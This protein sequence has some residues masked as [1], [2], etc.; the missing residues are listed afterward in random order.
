[1]QSRYAWLPAHEDPTRTGPYQ[2]GVAFT[3]HR[4]L[5]WAAGGRVRTS[6][7]TPG[8][9]IVTGGAGIDWLRVREPTE[10]LEVYPSAALLRAAAGGAV[11]PGPELVVGT[12][13]GVVLGIASVLR[14]VHATDGDLGDVAAST[15]AHRLAHHL[16]TRYAGLPGAAPGPGTL[17]AATVDRVAEY[18]DAALAGPLDLDR[19]AGVALLS[20]YHFA[21]AFRATTGLTPHGFVT[22]RRMDRARLLLRSG[23]APVEAVAAAVG[24]GNVS[25]F[26]R[27]FRRHTGSAPGELRADRKIRPGARPP[28]AARS[29]G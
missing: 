1:M 26:R 19:L 8:S 22:S 27:V 12:R 11:P 4:G 24:F 13:D 7:V 16:L 18:V 2:V 25:H 14:R 29:V 20:P 28:R 23:P 5:P 17:P 21:R 9:V 3:G 6:D 15:L 10:A